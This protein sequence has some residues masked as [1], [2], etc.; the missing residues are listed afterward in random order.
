MQLQPLQLE[1]FQRLSFCQYYYFMFIGLEKGKSAKGRKWNED[2]ADVALSYH[3][4]LCKKMLIFVNRSFLFLHHFCQEESLAS[5]ILTFES[6]LRVPNHASIHLVPYHQEI[7]SIVL[8]FLLP[9]LLL[10]LQFAKTMT[11]LFVMKQML[12]LVKTSPTIGQLPISIGLK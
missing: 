11:R 4:Y 5:V 12:L 1:V 2:A 8:L 9:L 6:I 7:H 10:V 3:F